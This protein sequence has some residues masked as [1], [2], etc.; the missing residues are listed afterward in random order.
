MIFVQKVY[1]SVYLSDTH[2]STGREPEDPVFMH[3][4]IFIWG[5]C[6]LKRTDEDWQ[7]GKKKTI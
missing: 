7:I 2:A 5:K 4:S 6:P 1:L 3:M